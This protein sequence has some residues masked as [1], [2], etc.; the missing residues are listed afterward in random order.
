MSV[1]KAVFDPAGFHMDPGYFNARLR[2]RKANLFLSPS[3]LHPDTSLSGS[4]A[5]RHPV[6]AAAPSSGQQL[7]TPSSSFYTLS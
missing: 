1:K 2:Q 3:H 4:R 6:S 7:K 5:P